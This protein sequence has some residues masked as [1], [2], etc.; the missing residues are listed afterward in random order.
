M[1]SHLLI[2]NRDVHYLNSLQHAIIIFVYTIMDSKH[3]CVDH[4]FTV[5]I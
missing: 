2:V 5:E 1:T 3:H 4:L